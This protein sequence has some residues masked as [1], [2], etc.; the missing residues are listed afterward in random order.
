MAEKFRDRLRHAWNVFRS[1]DEPLFPNGYSSFSTYNPSQTR[2]RVSNERSIITAVYNRIAIDVS[3]FDIRHIKVDSNGRYLETVYDGLQR[4]LEI[5]ANK[6]QTGRAFIR[7]VVMSMFDEG[8]VAVVPVDTTISPIVSGSYEINTLRTGK[9]VEWY[10]DQVKVELYNDNAGIKEQ[11]ILPKSITA[12]IENPLYSVMNEP[13]GIMRRLIRKL[14]LLDIVDEAASS[15]KLDLIIQLPYIIKSEARQAQ[16]EARRQAITEQLTNSKYGIAYTDGTEH[17]T[18][19]NRPVE[20]NLMG[21]I[22]YLTKMLYSQLGITEDVFNGK[23]DDKALL[24]YYNRTVEPIVT[25]ITEEFTRKFITKTA[26]TQGHTIMGFRNV[27]RLIPANEIAEM[28]DTLSRNEIMTANEIRAILGLKPSDAPQADE[29]RNKNMPI[30]E[31]GTEEQVEQTEQTESDDSD[32]DKL[33]DE[34][35]NGIQAEITKILEAFANDN[36]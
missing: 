20:N 28:A 7:D 1:R 30:Q 3:E 4:C 2:F 9:V 12:I 35:M 6:D 23:A 27:F 19:L 8:S 5:E 34:T 16:A 36:K 17:I 14:S 24:N 22:E 25:A 18:Q 15:G 11:I 29:L 33:F 13:N 26:H 10:P 31:E 21:Q 32:Y